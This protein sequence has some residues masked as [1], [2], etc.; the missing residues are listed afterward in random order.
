MTSSPPSFS[1]RWIFVAIILVMAILAGVGIFNRQHHLQKLTREAH[2]TS[3]QRVIVFAPIIES[4]TSLLALPANVLAFKDTALYARSPGYLKRWYADIGTTVKQN[5]LIAQ[6]ETPELDAQVR[7]AQSD[8]TSAQANYDLAHTTAVRWQALIM[9][10][11]VSVQDLENKLGDAAAKKALLEAARAHLQQLAA[12]QAFEQIR[13][14]FAGTVSVRN[15]D[16]GDLVTAGS[17]G[18]E[19]FHL[20]DKRQLRIY[21]QVPQA[22]AAD[23]M[24]GAHADITVPEHPGQHFSAAVIKIAGALDTQTRTVLVEL[25]FANPDGLINPGD[26]ANVNFK[27]PTPRSDLRIPVTALIFRG[28]GLQVARVDKNH[29]VRLTTVVPGRDFGKSMEIL[30]GI[31]E[32]ATIIDNPPDSIVE[33]EPVEIASVRKLKAE[34]ER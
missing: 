13:A 32:H 19:L 8:L 23:I 25:L 9:T 18:R 1:L 12:L 16:I 28:D 34:A 21:V 30:S 5:E 29:H 4:T 22:Q 15:V 24:L 20:V 26:F 17:T 7:Q 14:P 33:G 3:V 27:M 10:K 31:N 2:A 6:I 11:T